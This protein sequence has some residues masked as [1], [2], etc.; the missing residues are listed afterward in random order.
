M[1]RV[2]VNPGNVRGLGNIVSPK[3]LTDFS[4]CNGKLASSTES[5][6]NVDMTV[7]TS[8]YLA[9]SS[10]SLSYTNLIA[11][12]DT[13]FTISVAL[14]DNTD[15]AVNGAT[16]YLL[17]NDAS[18]VS[19]TTNSS[20]VATFSVDS[21]GSSKYNL[22]CYYD[23]SVSLGGSV[24]FGI[25]YCVDVEEL[26]LI[27]SKNNIQITDTDCL[28]ATLTGTNLDS[29]PVR[30]KGQ[31]IEIFEEYTEDIRIKGQKALQSGSTI[32]LTAELCDGED[33]S[34][35]CLEGETIEIYLNEG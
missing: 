34:R 10:L 32:N 1:E 20:G 33:G 8:S 28:I 27:A 23:G 13:S 26:T 16:V 6:N 2:I 18:P 21:D 35:L 22:K 12:T 17:V 24:A 30:I 9:G 4:V 11:T 5:V 3:T 15:S 19:A 31:L 14:K 7:Y 25:V 29:E